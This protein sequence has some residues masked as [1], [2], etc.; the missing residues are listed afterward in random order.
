[1]GA[2]SHLRRPSARDT[3]S[4]ARRRRTCSTSRRLMKRPSRAS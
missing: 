3:S 1:M 4:R 2:D